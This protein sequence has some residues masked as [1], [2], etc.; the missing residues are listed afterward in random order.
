VIDLDAPPRITRRWWAAGHLLLVPCVRGAL[1]LRVSGRENIPAQ[2]PV[3]V[4]SNHVSELDPPTLGVSALPR[5]TYY[6]AK[7]ELF[8]VPLLGRAVFRLGAFPV[9]RGGADRRAMRLAREV[10]GRGDLLLMFPEGTRH[11]DGRLRPGLPGAGSL[12]LEPGVTIVPAAIWGTQR[13]IGPARVAFGPPID[14]SDLDQGPRSRRSQVA[15]DRMMAGVAALLPRVGGPSQ[16]PP[17]HA[18]G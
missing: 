18:D 13:W 11:P 7:Q 1:R 16:D 3:L 12:G 8:S 6:M 10:L 5:K 17:V 15:V 14:L 2:G 4:V 9:D